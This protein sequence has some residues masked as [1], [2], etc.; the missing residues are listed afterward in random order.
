MTGPLAG[1]AVALLVLLWQGPEHERAIRQGR[2]ATLTVIVLLCGGWAGWVA[3]GSSADGLP[4]VPRLLLAGC[5][6]IVPMVRYWDSVVTE[7]Q[8]PLAGAVLGPW[9]LWKLVPL[10]SRLIIGSRLL[11]SLVAGAGFFAMDW[12]HGTHRLGWSEA[13]ASLLVQTLLGFIVAEPIVLPEL[14][15]KLRE[16]QSSY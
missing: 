1:V 6:V 5:I 9:M 10:Q 2:K 13:G 11:S 4:V 7:L 14:R 12:P 3:G 8:V 16:P 15:P